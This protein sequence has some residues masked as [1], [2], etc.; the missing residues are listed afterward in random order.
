MRLSSLMI[1]LVAFGVAAV[2]ALLAARS[3]VTI[4]E[5]RSVIAVQEALADANHGWASVIGDGLQ[6]VMEG[7]APS[8]AVRFRAMTVAGSMVDA[9]R[10]IDNMSVTATAAIAPPNFAI[11]ILRNDSGISLIGLIPA[12]VD[13]DALVAR[14][15]ALAR[16]LPVADLLEVADYPEP[17]LW[18]A[19]QDYSLDALQRLP[20]SKISVASG[21]VAVTAISDSAEHKARLEAEL[22]RSI[23][24]DVRVDLSI[25][26]PR[27]VI[28]PYTT[29]FILDDDGPRFD[30]CVADTPQSL[31]RIERAAAQLGPVSAAGCIEGLGAPSRRWGDAVV[32]GIDAVGKLGGGTITFSDTD[33]V[34]VAALQTPPAIFDEV[35]GELSNA[36]PDVFALDAT[37]PNPPN[38]A[39]EGPATF[40]AT[41]SPEGQVQLRGRVADALMNQTLENFAHA[42]FGADVVTMGTRIVEDLPMGWSVRMLAAVDALSELSNGAVVVTPDIITVRGNTGSTGANGRISRLLIERLGE[43]AEFEIDVTYVEALDPIAG[44]PTPEECVD[45]ILGLTSERKIIFDPGSATL[46]AESGALVDDIAEV[47]RRCADLKLEIAGYTDSQGRDSMN[48]D[49]SQQRANSVLA[50]LRDRRVPVGSFEA[51]GYGEA[52]PIADNGTEEGREANRRIEFRL[53]TPEPIEEV[54]TGLEA[55]EED[56]A[57]EIEAEAEEATAEPEADGE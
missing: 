3:L 34:L 32:M 41:L 39:E 31:D 1:S 17:E 38:S 27:P 2:G 44:L 53:I 45:K 48:L 6:I 14:V 18:A 51:I 33:V 57:A 13:R 56:L 24:E 55:L 49:L 9:S 15:E 40:T 25:S 19:A 26:A 5:E 8:E 28:T 42:Q 35:V 11:E 47:L 54:T 52:D 46:T 29:R 30:A 21:R 50:A 20:R 16:G 7:E 36:L 23:P 22:S 4:V 43:Q 37:L 12:S 10:V